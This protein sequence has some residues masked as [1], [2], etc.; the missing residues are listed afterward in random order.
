MKKFRTRRLL[1]LTSLLL[2][3]FLMAVPVFAADMGRLYHPPALT[4]LTEN[5]PH[6]LEVTI[7]LQ[8]LRK[9]ELITVP[10]EMGK[11]TRVWEQQF[12]LY[13]EDVILKDSWFGNAKDLNNAELI[14]HTGGKDEIVPLP[15]EITERMVGDYSYNAVMMFNYKT[16]KF[17]LGIPFWRGPLMLIL[18][19]LVAAALVIL[20]FHLRSFEERKTM[21]IVLLAALV[22][23]GLLNLSTSNWLNVDPRSLVLYILYAMIVVFVQVLADVVL[24]DEDAADGRVTT[25]LLANLPAMAFNS[26]A[27]F[28]LP[29]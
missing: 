5:A 20:I 19:T 6:D 3:L 10:V 9:R 29:Q 14:L 12:R 2:T 7:R 25:C 15:K 4:I 22:T 27:L 1:A 28:I 18:R 16:G 17:S 26:L 11:S 23:Y 24:L 21:L 13:R 8:T